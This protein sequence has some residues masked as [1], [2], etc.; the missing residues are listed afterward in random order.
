MNAAT[1]PFPPL[2]SNALLST[3]PGLLNTTPVGSSLTAT[4]RGILEPAPLYSVETLLPLSATH[5]GLVLLAARPQALTRFPSVAVPGTPLSDT[6]G[7]T[8]KLLCAAA[9]AAARTSASAIAATNAVVRLVRKCIGTTSPPANVHAETSA[10]SATGSTGESVGRFYGRTS[11]RSPN[12]CQRY[13]R[14]TAAA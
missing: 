5:H 11:S 6:S 10:C 13:P 12:S 9:A 1:P 3:T 8:V 14:S 4:V 7:V 2:T